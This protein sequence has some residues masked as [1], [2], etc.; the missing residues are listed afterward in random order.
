M[1][2]CIYNLQYKGKSIKLRRVF[3]VVAY[4]FESACSDLKSN[5]CNLR[6]KLL[7]MSENR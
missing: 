1:R 5:V 6:C 7:K 3:F 4:I 2:L